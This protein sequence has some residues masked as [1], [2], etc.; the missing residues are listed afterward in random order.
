LR[1]PPRSFAESSRS[2]TSRQRSNTKSPAR[3]KESKTQPHHPGG[4]VR[5]LLYCRE[6]VFA[7]KMI[8]KYQ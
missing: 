2:T 4:A 8:F 1:P 5:F 7:Q 3:T 6:F